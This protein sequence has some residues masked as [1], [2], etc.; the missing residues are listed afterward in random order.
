MRIFVWINFYSESGA[1]DQLYAFQCHKP[2]GHIWII[3]F[4][5]LRISFIFF[6]RY[7][8]LHSTLLVPGKFT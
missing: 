5:G 1:R 7:F 3:S 8:N 6:F 4:R 2:R